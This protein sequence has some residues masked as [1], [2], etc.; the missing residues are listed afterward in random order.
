MAG[1]PVLSQPCFCKYANRLDE[2][3]PMFRHLR[4][5]F[6]AL[7]LLIVFLPGR[8]PIYAE[9]KRVGDTMFGLATQCIQ[10]RLFNKDKNQQT[11]TI[12]N[13]ALKI[14]VKLGGVNNIL[15]PSIRSE[16][17]KQPVI[18]LGADVAHPPA[19]DD[20]RPSIAAVVSSQDAHP[21]R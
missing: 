21:S 19:G 5:E 10:A 14:N 16:I 1:M 4:T 11:Q 9:I 17:F 3:E 15:L 7:Q 20:K 13:I 12:S 18:F 6:P 2:V 8:T